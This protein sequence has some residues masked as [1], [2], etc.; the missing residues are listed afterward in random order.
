MEELQGRFKGKTTLA[1]SLAEEIGK[2]ALYLDL[3]LPSDCAKQR[4]AIEIKRP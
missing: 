3:E 2:Q 4:W 1:L